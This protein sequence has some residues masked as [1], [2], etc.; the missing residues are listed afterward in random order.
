MRLAVHP[1]VELKDAFLKSD[2]SGLMILLPFR[3]LTFFFFFLKDDN[4]MGDLCC[5]LDLG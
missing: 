4:E 3:I 2:V 5:D 1:Q